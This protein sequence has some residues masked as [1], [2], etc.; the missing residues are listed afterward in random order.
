MLSSTQTHTFKKNLNKLTKLILFDSYSIPIQITT[1]INNIKSVFSLEFTETEILMSIKDDTGIIIHEE[2]DPIKNTYEITPDE[3]Q[4]ISLSQDV[5]IELYLTEF[6]KL[7]PDSF[8]F[9]FDDAKNIIYKFIY[10]TFNSD[11]QT[12][13]ELM[14][15]SCTDK[16]DY[17]MAKEFS[18]AEAA[19]INEFLNWDYK[20]KNEFILNLIS[21]C[22]DY[23][24]LTVKKDN[25]SY[26]N[27]FSGK[28][29]YLDSNIIFRLAGFNKVERQNVMNAFIN[30]CKDAN[31][32]IC[33]T[34]HT[35]YE[36]KN[37]IKH[38]VDSI[39]SMFSKESPLS[40]KAMQVMSSKYA[41]LDFYEKY[42]VWCKENPSLI[43]D[44]E[45]FRV[46]LEGEIQKVVHPFE[47]KV[48][49]DKDTFKNHTTFSELFDDFN[50]YKFERYKNT[51]EEAIKTD[52]NNYLYMTGINSDIQATNFLQLKYYFITADHC[53][54]EWASMKR[55]GTIP[56]F[57]L[58]SV[59][60]SILLKYKG[61]SDDDYNAF[62]QFLNIRIVP[63]KDNHISEKKKMLA[64]ILTLN[65][66]SAIKER[67]VFDIESRLSNME[68]SIDDPIAFA[69]ESHQTI[70][71]E[72]LSEQNA[73]NEKKNEK[74]MQ[75]LRDQLEA[76]HQSQIECIETEKDELVKKEHNT[77]YL[78]GQSDII[79]KE[80]LRI[81]ER[82]E[83]AQK[84]L[85]TIFAIGLAVLLICFCCF[86]FIKEDMSN[87]FTEWYE[88]N[89]ATI[90]IISA[91]I[92]ALSKALKKILESH[93]ILVTDEEKIIQQLNDRYT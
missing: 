82:N 9:S 10:I 59:W 55:P 28:F 71:Q 90:A 65:E 16:K 61:R 89:A 7:N 6:L 13:L 78:E 22:F 34:N 84:A 29:F 51:Y 25:N 30:K 85:D 21:S 47:L 79:K 26:A 62:C 43:G 37:T 68:T 64:Y 3:Y 40:L 77:G 19:L 53:L 93:N 32:K 83:K 12:L 39:K 17:C 80:A 86:L 73:E 81:K 54:T 58:P 91:I 57:V 46:Y 33:Y 56:L 76:T 18:S 31:I 92:T 67:V 38:H 45:A 70:L 11:A 8:E 49:D 15:K 35:Y 69:E 50:Q 66:D 2:K 4:K 63:E 42:V 87:G 5:T 52:I 48:F 24:M 36:I 41:N 1:I 44:F 27:V 60:Y 23:C 88:K 14:N 75:K 74:D 20:P 72:K